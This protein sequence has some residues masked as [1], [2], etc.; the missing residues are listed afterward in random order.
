[1]EGLERSV[2]RGGRIRQANSAAP[3]RNSRLVA[4]IISSSDLL[5]AHAPGL[6]AAHDANVTAKWR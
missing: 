4:G 2:R 5:A 1:E 6:S 3:H